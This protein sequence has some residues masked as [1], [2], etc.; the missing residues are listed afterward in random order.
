MIESGLHR[1]PLDV[2]VHH[3]TL[4]QLAVAPLQKATL[5]PRRAQG[6]EPRAA[7]QALPDLTVTRI[8]R[9]EIVP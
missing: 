8:V 1:L 7:P 4:V 2:L 3:G 9:C 6:I 5:A